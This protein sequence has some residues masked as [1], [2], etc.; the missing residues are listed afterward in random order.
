VHEGVKRAKDGYNLWQVLQE[1]RKPC[2]DP[3]PPQIEL[4]EVEERALE[5]LVSQTQQDS[6]KRGAGASS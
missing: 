3:K 2:P 6:K 4:S 5:K 1:G